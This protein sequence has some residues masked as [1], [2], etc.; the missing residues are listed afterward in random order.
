MLHAILTRLRRS[1]V[2]IAAGGLLFVGLPLSAQTPL[3]LRPTDFIVAGIRDGLDSGSLRRRLG[4]PDSVRL[5]D[6]PSGAERKI[7]HWYY[8][9]TM[10]PLTTRVLGIN[11]FGRG[12]ATHRGRSEERRVGKECRSRWSP[13]H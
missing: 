4:T 12:V 13:Y 1:S 9:Q 8:R 10:V 7:A 6:S 3:P 2:V 11:L 5:V